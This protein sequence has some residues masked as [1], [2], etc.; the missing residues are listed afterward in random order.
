MDHTYDIKAEGSTLLDYALR[1]ALH[2][3][4]HENEG[5]AQGWR[6]DLIPIDCRPPKRNTPRLI[7][8][9]SISGATSD[10]VVPFVVPMDA[11]TL[12]PIVTR[13]LEIADYGNEPDTDGSCK[14]G[15]LRH[16]AAMGSVR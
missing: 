3:K 8:F 5:Y 6:E 4:W 14:K 11:A 2:D 1:I 12:L 13:W 15:C 7:L 10:K 16:R 9:A